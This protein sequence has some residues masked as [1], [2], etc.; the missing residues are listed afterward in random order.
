MSPIAYQTIRC[1]WILA[2]LFLYPIVAKV[3]YISNVYQF[4]KAER[5]VTIANR[6]TK[7]RD[8]D[9]KEKLK[10]LK[11]TSGLI[12]N[13]VILSEV[14]LAVTAL[15]IQPLIQ[16]YSLR[17]TLQSCYASNAYDV[18]DLVSYPQLRSILPG[19]LGFSLII[20]THS[21]F[22]KHSSDNLFKLPTRHLSA[23]LLL[24]ASYLSQMLGRIL[25]LVY[26][27]SIIFPG[28]D[29]LGLILALHIIM[30]SVIHIIDYYCIKKLSPNLFCI[31][32]WVE[33][34]LNGCASLFIP[35]DLSCDEKVWKNKS[36]GRPAN[37]WYVASTTRLI[38]M[39]SVIL[40]ES[41]IL[42]YFAY[43]NKTFD[44]PASLSV[45]LMTLG[46]G[47]FVLY[48][49]FA[50]PWTLE[51]KDNSCIDIL[52]SK[53]NKSVRKYPSLLDKEGQEVLCNYK[54]GGIEVEAATPKTLRTPKTP[55]SRSRIA[56]NIPDEETEM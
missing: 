56:F 28:Y 12:A 9:V 50:Y 36:N 54:V 2:L 55:R 40:C 53:Q 20:T 26:S 5:D 6:I 51:T 30:M 38:I 42:L 21:V 44:V 14:V 18:M 16:L 34:V 1:F 35:C 24:F 29:H 31:S 45:G 49:C 7:L 32:F 39:Y 3:V 22:V 43:E 37:R 48:Y 13:H 25:L 15:S 27:T 17:N 8:T 33:A 52:C 10:E 23:R 19:A 4:L 41:G 47:L 46:I 11:W